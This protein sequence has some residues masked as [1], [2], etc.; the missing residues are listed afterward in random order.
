MSITASPLAVPVPRAT[1]RTASTIIGV[2]RTCRPWQWTKQVFVLAAPGAA[3]SFRDLAEVLHVLVAVAAFCLAASAGYLFNDARDYLAD[4]EHPRKRFRPI[5]AGIVPVR[6][7]YAACLLLIAGAITLAWTGDSWRLAGIVAGYVALSLSYTAHFKH[8]A[9]LDV[10][11]VAS[12]FVVRAIGGAVAVNVAITHWFFIVVTVGSLYLVAGKREA[13]MAAAG[14]S[15]G[16]TRRILREY[17][18]S[19]LTM[20]RTV[21][22]AALLT[23]YTGW[24]LSRD[25]LS[26][27]AFPWFAVSLFPFMVAVLRYAL[28]LDKGL[29]EEPEDIIREDTPL[30]IAGLVMVALMVLGT[31]LP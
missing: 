15:A 23:S 22:L 25:E 27:H 4:R 30:M 17:S 5:A 12:L 3:G 9:V 31:Y 2:V 11:T 16:D 20:M 19:Y 7:A 6:L 18:L 10:V 29:G 13:E 8:V 28:R 21:S 26:Q 24:A 14:D 1:R